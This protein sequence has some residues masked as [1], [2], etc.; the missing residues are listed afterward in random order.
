M[1]SVRH[2]GIFVSIASYRDADCVETLADL[3][4]KAAHPERVHAG[5]LWQVAPEDGDVFT[6]RPEPWRQ[7]IRGEIVDAGKSMGVCWARHRIQKHF[8][9]GEPYYLQIDSHC[10]FDPEWDDRLLTLLREAPS[11]NPVLS[12][13]PH[14]FKPPNQLIKKG[15]PVMRAGRFD[16]HGIL[17]PEA[18][19]HALGD[20]P[21]RPMPSPFVGAGFVF[22]PSSI[23][24]KVP[25]DPFLYFQGEEINLSVR[26]WTWG[27]DIFSPNDVLVYHDYTSRERRRHWS[28]HVDWTK[29]NDRS[30]ARLLHLLNV[31]KST[32]PD[33]LQQMELYSLGEVRTLEEYEIFADVDFSKRRIGPRGKDALFPDPPSTGRDAV[34]MRQCF[35]RIYHNNQWASG[36]TRSGPGSAPRVTATLRDSL[37]TLWRELSVRTVVDAG[38]GDLLW[39]EA[40]T[41]DLGL[42]LGFDLVEALVVNNRVFYGARKNHF[43]NTADI[44]R[45]VL[46]QGDL[47]LCRNTLTHLS[48]SLVQ[49]ALA[50]FWA[51]G[52]RYLLATTF[53][54]ANNADIEV[55]HWRKVDLTASPFSLPP[56]LQMVQDGDGKNGCFQGLWL[57]PHAA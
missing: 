46:P 22:A 38:C 1:D 13:H 37:T 20:C 44:T 28:D 48:N 14:E 55:G 42:Y 30:F 52:S 2:P 51:S 50:H 4:T 27:Y 18:K 45:D 19:L 24:Q 9:D 47:L 31:R 53:P 12:T 6:R 16:N 5:V 49:A 15:I 21:R 56:P 33:T 3:F 36:E 39:L 54:G 23:I 40:I 26:L 7:Q 8:W 17:M 25:Y 43:F 57:N 11:E 29:L 35:R 34:A 10:R 32:D 41:V